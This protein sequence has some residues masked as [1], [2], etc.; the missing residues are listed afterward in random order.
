MILGQPHR[1]YAVCF[2]EGNLFICVLEPEF[3]LKLSKRLIV[4]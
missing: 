4:V 3:K 1:N 2:R